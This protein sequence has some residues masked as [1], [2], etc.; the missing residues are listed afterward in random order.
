MNKN[1]IIALAGLAAIAAAASA[2]PTVSVKYLGTGQGQNVSITFN[3]NSQNVFA[4][5]LRHLLTN[6]SAGYE[7]INGEHRTYCTDLYQYVTSSTKT[8]TIE[9]VQNMPGSSPMGI[10]KADALRALF[11]VANANVDTINA[12]NDYATGFQ[13]AIW[14]IVTDYSGSFAMNASSF[15]SG[16]FKAKKTNG[17]ALSSGV[18]SVASSAYNAAMN[19]LQTNGQ[20][21]DLLGIASG[22]AQD[23]LIRVPTPGALALAGFGGLLCTRR[24]RGN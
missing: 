3:G 11:A 14:E 16:N 9:Q 12:S 22:T 13:L 2:A 17:S 19:F 1:S 18:V 21:T 7:W 15:T 24:R 20:S 8:Y 23:Q 5:Q 4:G 10:A 6:A